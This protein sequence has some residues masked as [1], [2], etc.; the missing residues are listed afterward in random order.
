[1]EN[2]SLLAGFRIKDM[3]GYT[4]AQTWKYTYFFIISQF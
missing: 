2:E 3:V 1:M 4:D